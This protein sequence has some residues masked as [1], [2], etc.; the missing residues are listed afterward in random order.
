[1]E[2]QIFGSCGR[3]IQGYGVLKDLGRHVAYMGKAF[4]VIGSPRR[5]ASLRADV[6]ASFAPDCRLEFAEFG[7]E[8]SAAEVEKMVRHGRAM[9]AC[10]VI[11]LGGGKVHDTAKAAAEALHVP[12]VIVP[13]IAASDAATSST[14]LIYNDAGTEVVDCVYL[15]ASP[16]VVLVDTKI[17]VNAPTRFLVAGMGDALSTYLGARVAAAGYKE[18]YFG[19]LYTQTSLAIAKLSYDLL[20]RYGRQAKIASEQKAVTDAFN[21]IVEVNTLMSGMGF[22]NNGSATDHAFFFGAMALPRYTEHALHGEGVAFSCCCQ[23]VLEGSSSEQLDEVY[24]FCTD[25]GLPVTFEQIGLR[26]VTDEEMGLMADSMMQRP[27]NHPFAVTRE[28]LAA[29]YKTADAI[30]RMYLA[31]GRL[32]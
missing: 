31:G 18:N 16:A 10:A 12:V 29:A 7:G 28:K 25:V 5:L 26:D 30:G 4:L 6:E 20:M 13:T 3:Y 1:M 23:L 9:Q 15:N 17:I 19:G 32:I 11:G 8:S 24:R 27:I 21:T 22:E 14:A 2:Q